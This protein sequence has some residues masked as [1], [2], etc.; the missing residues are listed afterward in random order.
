MVQMLLQDVK[1]PLATRSEL[2]LRSSE[3][4]LE[5]PWAPP[6]LH[7][8][9]LQ[10]RVTK[11]RL[12][13]QGA[14][15]AWGIVE[16]GMDLELIGFYMYFFFSLSTIF[17]MSNFSSQMIII[18]CCDDLPRGFQF[19]IT[20]LSSSPPSLVFM[21]QTSSG[22]ISWI[23]LPASKEC[24]FNHASI[25]LDGFFTERSNCNNKNFSKYAYWIMFQ[26]MCWHPQFVTQKMKYC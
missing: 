16:E 21:D 12:L 14:H 2:E 8:T 24:H 4:L 3:R 20:T 25:T 5:Y 9:F 17:Q 11:M 10:K 19:A 22:K 23:W 1:S 13:A 18:K 26:F 7:L 15:E 6:C